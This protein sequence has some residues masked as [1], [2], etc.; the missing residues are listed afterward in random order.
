MKPKEI[1]KK[2][3]TKVQNEDGN[4]RYMCRFCKKN[5]KENVTRMT[6]HIRKECRLVPQHILKCL[7]SPNKAIFNSK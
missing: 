4:D 3:Y 5:Y 1:K 2:C 7:L 6:M